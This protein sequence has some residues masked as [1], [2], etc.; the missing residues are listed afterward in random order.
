[1]SASTTP[2]T[3]KARKQHCCTWCYEHIE[4]GR[5]YMRY[6]Y[7]DLGDAGTVKMHPECMS[8]MEDMADE[9][10]GNIEWTPGEFERP[11]VTA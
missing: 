6:R 5:L 9:E 7:F 11:K 4:I 8:A 2:E 3:L 1:M 10:G